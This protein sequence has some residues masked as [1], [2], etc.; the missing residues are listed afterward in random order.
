MLWGYD[1][2]REHERLPVV[3][4]ED[5]SVCVTAC[6]PSPVQTCLTCL[7]SASVPT[8]TDLLPG[9]YNLTCR[10][11]LRRQVRDLFHHC[12]SLLTLRRCCGVQADP[13]HI[14]GLFFIPLG[15]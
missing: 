9:R 3:A 2:M 10:I 4:E 11:R 8:W 5:G 7:Y 1:T 13:L 6:C 14:F 15:L 12:N